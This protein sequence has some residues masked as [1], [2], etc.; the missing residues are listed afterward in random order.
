MHKVLQNYNSAKWSPL[1]L[2]ITASPWAY[3]TAR[4]GLIECTP[5]FVTYFHVVEHGISLLDFR[6]Q[7]F[8]FVNTYWEVLNT[9]V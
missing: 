7:F 1:L 9:S 8:D 5:H 4:F 6:Q 2:I 3:R